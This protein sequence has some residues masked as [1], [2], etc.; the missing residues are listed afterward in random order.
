M[1]IGDNGLEGSLSEG[2]FLS[3]PHLEVLFVSGNRIS[4]TI[5]VV[6]WSIPSL[7]FADLSRNQFTG[8]LPCL[9]SNGSAVFN[10]LEN[11]LYGNLTYPLNKVR[12]IVD[13][14]GNFLEGGVLDIRESSF[15]L[16]RN[17]LRMAPNQRSL[18][19]YRK[20]YDNKGL[21]FDDFVVLAPLPSSIKAKKEGNNRIILVVVYV[22]LLLLLLFWQLL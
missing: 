1:E 15:N 13:L 18:K 4:G 3:L 9:S 22:F 10:L 2:L 21:S 5:P 8:V 17:C 20:F 14:S 12:F 16:G 11:Q 7:G 19:S 6:L